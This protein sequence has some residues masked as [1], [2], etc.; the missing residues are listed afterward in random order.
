MSL[1][2][3][4][5]EQTGSPSADWTARSNKK[6]LAIGTGLETHGLRNSAGV[7]GALLGGRG[8]SSGSLVSGFL[9][10]IA[11]TGGRRSSSVSSWR[12]GIRSCRGSV[13]GWCSCWSSICGWRRRFSRCDSRCGGFNRCWCRCRSRLF[14]LAT[15]SQRSGSDQGSDDERL[16]HWVSPQGTVIDKGAKTSSLFQPGYA[17]VEFLR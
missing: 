6:A 15:S 14:L 10:R 4:A 12:S 7:I 3:S 5:Q 2:S 1:R 9:G 13:G 16:V 11:F 8:S 17:L